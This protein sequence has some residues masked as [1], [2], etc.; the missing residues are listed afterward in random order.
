V[1]LVPEPFQAPP[2]PVQLVAAAE[3][4]VNV[5]VLP[6]AT[7]DALEVKVP[8]VGGENTTATPYIPNCCCAAG[9]AT[10]VNW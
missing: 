7:L 4:Q 2:L 6:V 10:N 5:T 3:F 1:P 9:V 8:I